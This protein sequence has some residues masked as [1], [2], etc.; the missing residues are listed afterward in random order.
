MKIDSL[1]IKNFRTISTE[2]VLQVSDGLT[3]VG[4]NNA[5]KTNALLALYMFFT[6]YENNHSYNYLSDL[7]HGDKSVKTS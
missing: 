3:L 2:Q 5:G 6:G 4:P 1:R 7:T